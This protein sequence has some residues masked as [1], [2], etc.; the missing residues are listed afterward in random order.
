M[1]RSIL[2]GLIGLVVSATVAHA[3]VI[4]GTQ[5]NVMG[6]NVAAYNKAGG[7]FSHCGMYIPYQS[8]ITMHYTIFANYH[9]LVGWSHA[10][11]NLTPGQ[12]VPISIVVDGS[13]PTALIA[14]ALNNKFAV[15]DLPAT[16]AVFDQMRKGNQM[17]V[18]ALSNEY[19]FN[20]N[21]TYAA[22]TDLVACVN[23]FVKSAQPPA[24]ITGSNTP[25]PVQ[26]APALTADQRLEATTLVANLLSQ[27]DLA[28]FRILSPK[29]VQESA[30]KLASWHVV[31]RADDVIGTMKILP[32]EMAAS[33][34][35]IT[36]AVIASD[37]RGCNGQFASGT[38]P[39]DKSKGTT[40]LFAA[41]KTD[42]LSWEAHYIIVPRD[43]GGF[44]LFATF[45]KS[46]GADVAPTVNHADGL[47]RAAVFQVLKH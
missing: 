27:G 15:A 39:D 29:E 26:T 2:A 40:R 34:S 33:T 23:G 8:G 20:L 6:W 4:P 24:P 32:R 46:E 44:Y 45:G 18:Y 31:W 47:L 19:A 37:S 3:D 9:W 43:E 38:T 36:S 25:P 5:H 11:W 12:Q 14:K 42:K 21:G 7:A 17:R 41:C 30:P 28:G 13:A 16:A 35:A 1:G 10:S 22:L